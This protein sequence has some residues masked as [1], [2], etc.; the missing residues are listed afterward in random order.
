[1]ESGLTDTLTIL[2]MMLVTAPVRVLPLLVL[3]QRRLPRVLERWLAYV[4]VAVL[5]AMLFPS[6]FMPDGSLALRP[7]NLFLWAA[8]P[9]GLVAWKT[10]A[11]FPPVLTGVAVLALLRL[12]V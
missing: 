5:A 1:M 11:L 4:P 2:G 8:L 6:I 10:R 7:D 3:S 9:A 12:F